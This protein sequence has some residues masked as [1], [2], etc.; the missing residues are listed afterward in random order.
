ML[1]LIQ[2]EDEWSF[3]RTFL[4][5]PS[6]NAKYSLK[7]FTHTPE[8]TYYFELER[9]APQAN[10]WL[11]A[12]PDIT[13]AAIWEDLKRIEDHTKSPLVLRSSIYASYE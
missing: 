10:K 11:E 6:N 13:R 2:R 8:K 12:L 9:R 3:Y 1:L 5:N 4:E 7:F